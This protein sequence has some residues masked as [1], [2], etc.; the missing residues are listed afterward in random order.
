MDETLL[1]ALAGTRRLR[2]VPTT[3][4]EADTWLSGDDGVRLLRALAVHAVVRVARPPVRRPIP[5]TAPEETRPE[6]D[7]RGVAAL[8]RI[9]DDRDLLREGIGL[10]AQ[11]GRV[12]PPELVLALLDKGELE[13]VLGER[14]RW[15]L[16][17]MGRDT[18]ADP[19]EAWV[20]GKRAER[21]AWLERARARE[22]AEARAAVEAVFASEPAEL[23][24]AFVAA[25]ATG[26]SPDDEPFLRLALADRAPGVRRAAAER[27]ACLPTF[28]A[29]L[30]ARAA[31]VA[32]SAFT[33]PDP[34]PSDWAREGLDGATAR[35]R[36]R[37]LVSIV[38]PS[39]WPDLDG[40]LADKAWGDVLRPAL[41]DAAV[42]HRSPLAPRIFAVVP[43]PRLLTL[44]PDPHETVR[45][46]VPQ[47]NGLV[48]ELLV[49]L[50][51]P[52]PQPL[53]S[54]VVANLRHAFSTRGG[55]PEAGIVAHRARI[56]LPVA[57]AEV[58]AEPPA[59]A[60]PLTRL[61]EALEARR[62]VHRAL[63]GDP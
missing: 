42:L 6:L 28:A 61:R 38:D 14:G 15:L 43:S 34:L 7:A 37:A 5:P 47:R 25:F 19:P 41:V 50:P 59:T 51:G 18:P 16:H 20:D 24:A 21:L 55:W 1:R 2:G 11:A 22:P 33:L 45:P 12:L 31:Q 10:V 52:W 9:A 60:L 56:A 40:M 3:G 29:T 54:V 35:D 30:R 32:A 44:L 36:L 13:P 57:F 4:T 46:W 48:A 58:L 53:S 39:A 23:R 49:A 62:A 26:L 27:L 63:S 8:R 17:R